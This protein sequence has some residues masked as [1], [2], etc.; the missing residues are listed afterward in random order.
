MLS[1]WR[2]DKP[3]YILVTTISKIRNNNSW[4]KTKNMLILMIMYIFV[5]ANVDCV[6]IS[7]EISTSQTF[8]D[9]SSVWKIFHFNAPNVT[10]LS[11][12]YFW[13]WK[14]FFFSEIG[15]CTSF[16]I[17]SCVV[18]VQSGHKG[19]VIYSRHALCLILGQIID[20]Y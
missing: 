15:G 20:K 1:A 6:W 9:N 18:I 12:C 7:S 13:G 2:K 16:W 14:S 17:L 19:G 3:I 10:C 8:L 11:V 5:C 4:T